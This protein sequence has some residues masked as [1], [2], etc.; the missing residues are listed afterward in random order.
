MKEYELANMRYEESQK[1][2]K[3]MDDFKRQMEKS[4]YEKLRKIK[5]REEDAI[6]LCK[7]KINVFP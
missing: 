5:E 4:N 2:Q 6:K 7:A 3:K 1:F